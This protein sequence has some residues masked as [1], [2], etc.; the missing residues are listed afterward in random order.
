MRGPNRLLLLVTFLALPAVLLQSVSS[1]EEPQD[2]LVEYNEA[3]WPQPDLSVIDDSNRDQLAAASELVDF[4]KA[5]FAGAYVDSKAQ[6]IVVAA[7]DRG[8]ALAEDALGDDPGV[9]VTRGALSLESA[10][11]LGFDLYRGEP[12]VGEKMWQWAI[13]PATSALRVGI[14]KALSEEDRAAIEK[15]AE[16]NSLPIKIYVDETA[17]RGAKDDARLEDD[18]PYSGGFRYTKANGTTSSASISGY[19]SGGFGYQS[20]GTNYMLTAGHCFERGTSYDEMWNT[21]SGSCCVKKVWA[22]HRSNTTWNDGDGTVAAGSDNANH[23][24]LALVN[25]DA[26]NRNSGDQIW[27]DGVTSPNKIPVTVRRVPTVGD[28]ICING[29]TSGADCGLTV[30]DTNINHVYSDGDVLRNGDGANS[31][32]EADCSQPGDSGGSIV[33]NHSGAETQA[34]AE[35]IVSGHQTF[36]IGCAQYFTGIEEAIQAWGGNVKFN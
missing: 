10:S 19:C 4:N 5:D 35:G 22:G 14:F 32:S 25:V 12:T 7:T 6:L 23:G 29:V 21:Q 18:S 34:T 30:F 17:G 31:T 36:S 11:Q 33:Y 3:A 15:F 24:D 2:G 1:A 20:G 8:Q 9:T 13:D 28:P 27:W 26:A 16:A